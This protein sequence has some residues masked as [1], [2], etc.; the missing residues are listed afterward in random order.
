MTFE[1]Y[2]AVNPHTQKKKKKNPGKNEN[3]LCVDSKAVLQ[4]TSASSCVFVRQKGC[5]EN[6]KDQQTL[7]TASGHEKQACCGTKEFAAQ[8][9]TATILVT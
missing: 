7:S 6:Q 4:L 9:E 5:K 2:N 1:C 8:R 3:A